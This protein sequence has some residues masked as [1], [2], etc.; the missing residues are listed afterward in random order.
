M[1]VTK[2][3]EY[4]FSSAGNYSDMDSIFDAIIIS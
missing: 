3:W 4:M 1:L 2:P